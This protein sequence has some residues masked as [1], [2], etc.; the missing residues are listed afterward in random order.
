[1]KLAYSTPTD[2]AA[3]SLR[4]FDAYGPAGY[5][6]LQL[7]YNQ[8]DV[9]DAAAFLALQADRPGLGSGLVTGGTLADDESVAALR[10]VFAFASAVG[11]DLVIYCHDHSRDGLSDDLLRDLAATFSEL[12]AEAIDAGTK[13]SIHN[14]FGCPIMLPEDMAVF[15][16][17]IEPGTV[18][19]TVDTAHLAKSG[20][21]D[22]SGL[23]RRFAHVID[24]FHLK[25]FDDDWRVLGEGAIDFEPIFAAIKEIGYDGWVSTDEES[26][27][28]FVEAMATC[29]RFVTEGLR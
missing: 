5:D 4:L 15:Y 7:K 17:A 26:G 23:I 25:D 6:G 12:G 11:S 14:H 24:N 2:D 13:L 3:Q 19:L 21:S 22:M 27:A 1:M 20:V 28:D 10:K 9:D 18:G 8:Y 16:D 29:R